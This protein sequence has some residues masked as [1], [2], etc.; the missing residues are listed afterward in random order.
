M[1]FACAGHAG[2]EVAAFCAAHMPEELL[3][4]LEGVSFNRPRT[5]QLHDR[6]GPGVG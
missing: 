4:A 2:K 6:L 1:I 5:V 3:F